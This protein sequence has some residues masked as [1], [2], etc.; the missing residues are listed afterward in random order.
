MAC[1]WMVAHPEVGPMRVVSDIPPYRRLAPK[2]RPRKPLPELSVV[3]GLEQGLEPISLTCPGEVTV[4]IAGPS[5]VTIRKHC[6]RRV[7]AGHGEALEVILVAG[8]DL[9]RR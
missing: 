8:L 2:R 3:Y 4:Q 9:R 7:H 5:S 6:L 1:G